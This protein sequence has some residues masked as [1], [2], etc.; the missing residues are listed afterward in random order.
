MRIRQGFG[1]AE[2]TELILE[3]QITE[4]LR[5]QGS[6]AQYANMAQRAVFTRR[7]AAGSI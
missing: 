2:A 3:H 5:L 4:Y 6:V 1:A 7:N